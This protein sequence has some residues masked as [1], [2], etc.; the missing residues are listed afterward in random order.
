MVRGWKKELKAGRNGKFPCLY[1]GGRH[2]LPGA[3]LRKRK[4]RVVRISLIF[5][6]CAEGIWVVRSG[7][8]LFGIFKN[9]IHVSRIFERRRMND[10][11]EDDLVT[12]PVSL[13]GVRILFDEKAV[14]IFRVREGPE[15][16]GD[17]E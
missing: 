6:V 15:K 5:A 12:D 2:K 1:A 16:E 11:V 13:D 9:E 10:T 8:E 4:I 7:E 14:T 3:R 17:W